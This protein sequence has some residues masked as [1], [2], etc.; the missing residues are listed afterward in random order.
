MN[1]LAAGPGSRIVAPPTLV[2]G[3]SMPPAQRLGD[4]L[5]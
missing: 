5:L 4:L 2:G 3:P 1:A